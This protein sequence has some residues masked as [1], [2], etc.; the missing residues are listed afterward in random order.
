[1]SFA[2]VVASVRA[3]A[4]RQVDEELRQ[5][6]RLFTRQLAARTEH[7][8]AATRLVSGDFALKATAATADHAT[9]ASVLENRRRRVGA[10]VLMLIS[11]DGAVVVDTRHPGRHGAPFQLP[12]LLEQTEQH[13]I[14]TPASPV[15]FDR[16]GVVALGCNIH[17]WMVGYIS[18]L[19]TPWFARTGPDGRARLGDVPAGSYEVRVWHPQMRG[20][21][22]KTARPVSLGAEPARVEHTL[23][24][25]RAYRPPRGSGR[26]DGT[27]GS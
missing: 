26:D 14:G 1:V 11:L 27:Q 6:G 5:A 13:H 17:D 21:T 23:A 16:P 9:T 15:V 12:R 18:V 19:P 7:L 4:R 3:S 22:D 8:L 20:D 2:L 10:D 25:R 24:L